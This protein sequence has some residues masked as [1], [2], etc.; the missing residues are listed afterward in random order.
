MKNH[1]LDEILAD[2][3]GQIAAFGNFNAA[4]QRLFFGLHGYKCDGRL[5]FYCQK[6]LEDER[7]LV[8]E[9]VDKALD[10]VEEKIREALSENLSE[11]TILYMLARQTLL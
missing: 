11:K 7:H 9:A 10:I 5:Q 6:V 8:Y 4:R 3:L 2:A 1:A